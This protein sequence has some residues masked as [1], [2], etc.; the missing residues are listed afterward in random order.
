V[1][2]GLEGL[3][4]SKIEDQVRVLFEEAGVVSTESPEH[5]STD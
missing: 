5:R 4:I 2:V 3:G 1:A